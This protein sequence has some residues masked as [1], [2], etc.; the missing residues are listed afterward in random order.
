VET[1]QINQKE[2]IGRIKKKRTGI[3][4]KIGGGVTERKRPLGI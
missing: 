2:N 1:K 4:R 3:K